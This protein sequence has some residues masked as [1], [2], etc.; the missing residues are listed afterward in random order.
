[1]L[2]SLKL[3][4]QVSTAIVKRYPANTV[5]RLQSLMKRVSLPLEKQE[6]VAL[7]FNSQ[8]RKAEEIRNHGGSAEQIEE[9]YR[10]QP[11]QYAMML[12]PVQYIEYSNS[13]LSSI[14]SPLI[15]AI[16]Y[17]YKLGLNEKQVIALVEALS[18]KATNGNQLSATSPQNEFTKLRSVLSKDQADKYCV[19]V[20]MSRSAAIT[21][22]AWNR[23]KNQRLGNLN[24]SANT[25][26][27][28]YNYQL[29]QFA[30]IDREAYYRHTGNT[31]SLKKISTLSKPYILWKLDAYEGTL[32]K[33]LM[34]AAMG[35]R[36]QI[37][38]SEAQV[39]SLLKQTILYERDRT[40][41][42]VAYPGLTY[43]EIFP[44]GTAT[45]KILTDTQYNQ[46]LQIKN[47]VI[48]VS[49]A[50]LDWNNLKKAGLT[51]G[52]DSAATCKQNQD[53]E[54]KL[55]VATERYNN[56]KVQA[57]LFQK[58]FIADHKPALLRKLETMNDAATINKHTKD[59]FAW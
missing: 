22:A 52:S 46:F 7:F 51:S 38:L 43:N 15:K 29:E 3:H 12:T 14:S 49:K 8:D 50:K 53:Y 13:Q 58:Q 10:I 32:P 30:K 45:M 44:Q 20:N 28:I 16:L 42:T 40:A 47:A 56:E 2:L 24:D 37:K 27:E 6:Q 21:N 48:S 4:A 57:N 31:D 5:S 23:I 19:V 18:N 1:M 11:Q 54:L 34:T 25:C 33:S 41:F 35:M 55:L 59:T 26:K 39:D 17:R 36:T 9:C